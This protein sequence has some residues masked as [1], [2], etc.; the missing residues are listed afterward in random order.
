[1]LLNPL[2]KVHVL[3]LDAGSR[4]HGDTAA[5]AAARTGNREF[6]C[7]EAPGMSRNEVHNHGHETDRV[8]SVSFSVFV[9]SCSLLFPRRGSARCRGP[10]FIPEPIQAEPPR[11]LYLF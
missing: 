7:L 3:W 4:C 10:A 1:M 8:L 2:I 9:V 6:V 5:A 11:H